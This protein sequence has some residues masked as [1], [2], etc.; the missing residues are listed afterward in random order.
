MDILGG[1]PYVRDTRLL[2]GS[3]PR[4]L[5]IING[6]IRLILRCEGGER[7]ELE[8]EGQLFSSP[9]S[10]IRS[11]ISLKKPRMLVMEITSFQR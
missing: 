4:I 2:C 6:V 7:I 1:S 11:L 5:E 9:Q 8:K 3:V 10:L